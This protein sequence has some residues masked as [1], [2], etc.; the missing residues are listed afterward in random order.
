[1]DKRIYKGV[2]YCRLSKE[3]GNINEKNRSNSIISQQLYCEEYVK[4][5]Q[6]IHL[7]RS[8]I[9]DDGVSGV[10]F[11]RRGFR[12]L[13]HELSL[14][15]IDCIICKD[16]SRFS[17]NYIEAGKYL[18]QIF[19]LNNIRFIA[20]NDNYDSL[21]IQENSLLIPF[22]NLINDLYSKD[23]STKIR[24]SLD[25]KRK[26]GEFVGAFAPYGYK[27]SVD[28]KGRLIIDEFV[29]ENVRFIFNLY[30]NGYTINQIAEKLNSLGVL[31]PFDH[32]KS[33]ATNYDTTFKIYPQGK[34]EYNTV[35]R[36][37]CNEVYTGT[38]IQGKR[39]TINHKV[40]L[41]REKSSDLWIR[42]ENAHE[43]LI[44]KGDFLAINNMLQR[45]TRIVTSENCGS[46]ILSGF[47]FCGNCGSSMVRKKVSKKHKTYIYYICSHNKKTKECTPNSIPLAILESSIKNAVVNKL[48][49]CES[50]RNQVKS[51]Y[52]HEE[53]V[54]FNFENQLKNQVKDLQRHETLKLNL[55]KD[56]KENIISKD[57][58]FRLKNYYSQIIE[59]KEVII[60][61][62][63]QEVKFQE[64]NSVFPWNIKS[65][66][67]N[68]NFMIDFIDLVKVYKGR[69]VDVIFKE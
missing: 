56:V 36:I 49:V 12:E 13:E 16:L 43:K 54:Y 10:T 28:K 30:K 1:M 40:Q 9:I 14:K 5:Q 32:K 20:I 19:P 45:E 39:G 25:I 24:S 52:N 21:N 62:L 29:A 8:P 58:Y 18:E 27:K 38:L 53:N 46:N 41:V 67:L 69:E 50:F 65:F 44:S 4:N 59:E 7:V 11:N 17:R 2:I 37:L 63:K 31:T 64:E 42:T 34:W 68:R 6:D 60:S 57:E 47:I 26:N 55:H 48:N 22:K 35:K 15:N 51:M 33:T 66:E 3:D 61:Q 23:I